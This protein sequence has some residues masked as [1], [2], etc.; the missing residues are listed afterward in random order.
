MPGVVI[1]GKMCPPLC[2]ILQK[3]FQGIRF[4]VDVQPTKPAESPLGHGD[5]TKASGNEEDLYIVSQHGIHSRGKQVSF[6][7]SS[8]TKRT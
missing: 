7:A 3:V 5:T 4:T 8:S 6:S 2:L 1:E